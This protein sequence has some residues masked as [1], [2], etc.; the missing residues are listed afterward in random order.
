MDNAVY[1]KE[2]VRPVHLIGRI[3]LIGVCLSSFLPVAYLYLVHGVV[4]PMDW[5][6]KDVLL[7]TASFG[8]IWLIEPITFY[9]ALGMIGSY[10]AFLTGN[11]GTSKLPASAVAQDIIKVEPGSRQAEV[12]SSMAIIG[13]IITTVGFVCVGALAGTVLLA[14]LPAEVLNAIKS[15]TVPAVF[16]SLMV[17]FAIKYPKVIPVAIGV[18]LLLRLF[19]KGFVPGYLFI[20]FTIVATIAAAL[21]IYK[22][23]IW[24]QQES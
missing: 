22:N 20:V 18:P 13:S 16:G 2:W 1:E 9:P 3:T 10:L 7:I 12:V 19:A 14:A 17:S 24:K 4:P 23:Q 5:I 15:Y 21:L 11:I 6:I 8:F